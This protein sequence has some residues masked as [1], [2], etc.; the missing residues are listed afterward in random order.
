V[1]PPIHTPPSERWFD[2]RGIRVHGLDWGGE[3]SGALILFLHGI[4][5]NAWI[6]DDVA[7]RLATA[8][9]S[10]RLVAIDGRDGGDTDHPADGY[11]RADFIADIVA[12]HDRLGGRPMVVVGHSRGGWLAAAFA[13]QHPDRVAGLVLVDPARLAFASPGDSAAFYDRVRG[14]LGPFESEAAALASAAREDPEGIWTEVR[15][16]SFLFGYRR[17][18][19]GRLI[20]KL[21][22]SAVDRLRAARTDAAAVATALASVT[23]PT[24]LLVAERQSPARVADKLAYAERLPDV[25]TVRIDGSH[26]L[27]TDAP[28][29]VAAAI[30]DFLGPQSGG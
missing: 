17:T 5:G 28:E 13:G 12:V 2:G 23:A 20:G 24:L 16:R 27:H 29:A 10:H 3:D 19:D 25:R 18:A 9:P 26:F 7:P 30:V 15:T 11:E 22:A 1:Q 8:L 4:G 6:W 14:A 21:P